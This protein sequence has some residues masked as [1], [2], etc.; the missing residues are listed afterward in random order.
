MYQLENSQF[1]VLKKSADLAMLIVNPTS[2]ITVALSLGFFLCFI[3]LTSKSG[4]VQTF[5]PLTGTS[6]IIQDLPPDF[7]L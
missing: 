4:H 3:F 1:V 6:N 5:F 7:F 2:K